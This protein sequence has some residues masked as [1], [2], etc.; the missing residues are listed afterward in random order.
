MNKITEVEAY[1]EKLERRIAKMETSSDPSRLQ[2]NLF[3]YK[4]SLG[5]AKKRC[6]AWKEDKPFSDGGGPF[7]AAILTSAMGFTGTGSLE[8]SFQTGSAMDYIREAGQ[9]GLPAE[10]AC[11]MAIMPLSMAELEMIP[12]EDFSVCDQHACTPMCLRELYVG[13]KE[14]LDMFCIDIPLK[15][16]MDSIKFVA[17][18][19][20]EFV[21]YCESKYP[22]VKYDEARL[23]RD[24]D[25]QDEY[26]ELSLKTYEL[27]KARPCPI[28]GLDVVSFVQSAGLGGPIDQRLEF[29]RM[30]YEEIKARVEKGI[31]A[32]QN[33]QLRFMWTVTRPFYMNPFKVLQEN[34]VSVPMFYTGPVAHVAPLPN[35]NFWGDTKLSPLERVA[36]H[37][38][39]DQWAHFGHEW[40][41]GMLWTCKDLG[42]D[43]IINFNMLGCTATLGLKKPIEDKAEELDISVL[44][45]EAREW[46]PEYASP[47]TI[48]A[49]LLDFV[50][51]VKA[52]KGLL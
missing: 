44:Q 49:Q 20:E 37:A 47:E 7:M 9:H 15:R 26:E 5:E 16:N 29:A 2:S 45:L 8:A 42:I 50:N 46:D 35:R 3:R 38:L 48:N 1:I 13:Y 6:E 14:D 4:M 11:D 32:V 17:K 34:N 43:G 21:T 12:F 36:A 39:Q 28:S 41:D 19:L 31:G 52:K 51:M 40:V 27:L 33:E 25:M 18:Q 23:I 22:G 24:L 30:R 10:T